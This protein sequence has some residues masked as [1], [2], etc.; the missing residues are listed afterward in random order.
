MNY[1]VAEVVE[2]FQED[3]Y[4]V[5]RRFFD[6]AELAEHERAVDRYISDVLPTVPRKHVVYESGWSGPLR[7]FSRLELYDDYFQQFFHRP[8]TL[9]L[10][11]ACLGTRVEP[12]ASEV[13]YKPARIGS[14]A[15]W[16]Q[17]NA[18]FNYL[19]PFGLVVWIAMDDVTIENGALSFSRGSHKLG[20]LPHRETGLPLVGKALAQPPDPKKFPE[21]PA[22]LERGDATI[23]H[24]LTAHRS[25]PNTTDNNRRG[26]V[27]DYGSQDAKLDEQAY[28]EQE[29]YKEQIYKKSG[30]L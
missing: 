30:A 6:R 18:Y 3:G 29:A 17:D 28:A 2:R 15:L 23:H 25:G 21:V 24:F 8:A 4:A 9:E 12:I 22:I 10:V 16:H 7:H 5:V 19:P 1:D 27:L 11:E 20:N 26:F 13:F 14:P